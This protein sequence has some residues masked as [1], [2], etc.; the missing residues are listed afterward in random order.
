MERIQNKNGE[1]HFKISGDW[2]VQSQNLKEKYPQL[3]DSDLT[4]E[5][6]KEN[7]LITQICNRLNKHRDEVI[8]I[9][10][11]IQVNQT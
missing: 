10:R 5:S 4:F 6:G 3:A 7:E 1:Q 2:K 8:N 11:K 9:L